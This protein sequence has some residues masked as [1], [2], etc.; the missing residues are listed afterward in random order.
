M[1]NYI[2]IYIYIYTYIQLVWRMM[3]ITLWQVD[4]LLGNDRVTSSYTIAVAK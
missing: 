1:N 3:I 4:P 2:Y